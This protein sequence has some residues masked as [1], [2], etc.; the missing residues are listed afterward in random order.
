MQ[1]VRFA[2]DSYKLSE[3]RTNIPV[4]NAIR[5]TVT[6]W[7]F[8]TGSGRDL[9]EQGNQLNIESTFL[10]ENY[11]SLT[12]H[13]LDWCVLLFT[14]RKLPLDY[15]RYPNYPN[16]T[17]MF[18][19]EILDA[20]IVY[21]DNLAKAIVQK[22]DKDRP[23]SKPTPKQNRDAMIWMIQHV[24]EQLD[25]NLDY[26]YLL[27]EVYNY[28]RRTKKLLINQIMIDAAKKFAQEKYTR[29]KSDDNILVKFIRNDFLS[30]NEKDNIQQLFAREHC[31]RW[32]LQTHKM[33]AIEKSVTEKEFHEKESPDNKETKV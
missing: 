6:K 30:K 28:L 4:S 32:Y 7:R 25:K 27:N 16:F 23:I 33:D 14:T 21:K 20:F 3:A 29:V 19:A 13:E 8:Q 9:D 24:K 15:K 31:V 17:M 5:A 12:V 1:M 26:V 18:M 11:P 10:V 22:M 2:F